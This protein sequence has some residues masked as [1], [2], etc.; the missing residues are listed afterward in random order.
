MARHLQS[1]AAQPDDQTLGSRI[2]ALR[3]QQGLTQTQLAAVR[4]AR[5]SRNV[6][7]GI[8]FLV[9]L[10]C[11]FVAAW[12]CWLPVGPLPTDDM[13]YIDAAFKLQSGTYE[14]PTPSF[15]Y[16]HYLR[17]PVILP[18]AALFSVFG[19]SEK[20]IGAYTLI[21][22]VAISA[23]TYFLVLRLYG[24]HLFAAVS[25]LAVF[26]V[27]AQMTPLLVRS[28]PAALFWALVSLLLAASG[29][30]RYNRLKLLTSGASFALAINATQIAAF[31]APIVPLMLWYLRPEDANV[32]AVARRICFFLLGLWLTYEAIMILE[33]IFLG[34]YLIQY[35][36]IKWWHLPLTDAVVPLSAYVDPDNRTYFLF[37]LLL[38][39]MRS[40]PVLFA[41]L[42]LL[43]IARLA[44]PPFGNRASA[45]LLCMSFVAIIAVEM[46]GALVIQ[47]LYVRFLAIP[48]YVLSIYLLIQVVGWI[49]SRRVHLLC[50]S[51]ILLLL[52]GI[53]TRRNVTQYFVEG[54][55]FHYYRDPIRLIKQHIINRGD[56]PKK[57]CIF[58]ENDGL[59]GLIQW[60]WAVKCYSDYYLADTEILTKTTP[61]NV[62][63]RL[64]YFV[65]VS[66]TGR[67]VLNAGFEKLPYP[68]LRAQ[69]RPN[70]YV[71]QPDDD[72][73]GVD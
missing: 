33:W 56:Q 62:D 43:F 16:H 60:N 17:W 68:D 50:L 44:T 25:C 69:S 14:A 23:A 40:N 20:V 71:L 7:F 41:L 6:I 39:T 65:S 3:R 61:T 63:D 47:K 13:F 53:H 38:N 37:G 49:H 45:A 55:A 57:V 9:A 48:F 35:K 28:E 22:F 10:S 72:R 36:A 58:F 8:S 21:Y 54:D 64:T 4:S 18:L 31:S 46:A 30:R 73:R 27:P 26:I 51:A 34:D 2:R 29:G 52:L 11:L 66:P 32:K 59:H 24:R 1:N 12:V 5:P 19:V 15:P 70:V 67:A 42:V